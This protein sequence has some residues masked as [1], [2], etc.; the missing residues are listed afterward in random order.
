MMIGPALLQGALPATIPCR[1]EHPRQPSNTTVSIRREDR[2]AADEAV[3]NQHDLGLAYARRRGCMR[4]DR[5]DPAEVSAAARGNLVGVVTNGT[6]V[7][8]L[9]AIGPPPPSPP[10]QG[11]AVQSSPSTATSRSTAQSDKPST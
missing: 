5:R 9:G 1:T 4:R 10:V 6:V 11:G 8:G 2:A 7:L 3:T